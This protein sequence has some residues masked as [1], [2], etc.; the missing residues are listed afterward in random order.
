MV[1]FAI[2]AVTKNNGCLVFNSRSCVNNLSISWLQLSFKLQALFLTC[3]FKPVFLV[4]LRTIILCIWN[5]GITA[6]K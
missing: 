4:V 1:E 2:Y 6:T 5:F 3:N